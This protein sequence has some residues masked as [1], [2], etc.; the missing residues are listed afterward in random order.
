MQP[1]RR[2]P[3]PTMVRPSRIGTPMSRNGRAKPGPRIMAGGLE[4]IPSLAP[5]LRPCQS[6][7]PASASRAQTATNDQP[8]HREPPRAE[9]FVGA[10][11]GTE[12]PR[13]HR[14]LSAPSEMEEGDDRPC[15][16]ADAQDE[17]AGSGDAQRGH[18]RIA[19][20]ASPAR[21]LVGSTLKVRW[22]AAPGRWSKSRLN[23]LGVPE[24]NPAMTRWRG[25]VTS[26]SARRPVRHAP[27]RI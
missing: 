20:L 7:M 13:R 6:Q 2:L 1:H 27:W 15:T 18:G 23:G 9:P 21:C 22:S 25:S 12:A 11:H 8:E 3:R 17:I 14:Q 10:A 5:R 16:E 19:S 26:R 24:W 4:T